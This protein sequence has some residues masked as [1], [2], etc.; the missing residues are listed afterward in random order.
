M[1][2]NLNQGQTPGSEPPPAPEVP[3]PPPAPPAPEA[4]APPPPVAPVAPAAPVAPQ[5][6][7]APP[8]QPAYPPPAQPVYAPPPPYPQTQ[9][10]GGEGQAI[11]A[12][13]IGI[14]GGLTWCLPLVGIPLA[15]IGIVL[16]VMGMKSTKRTLA[17]IGIVFCVLSL[18]AGIG[19]S[20]V[21]AVMSIQDPS[22]YNF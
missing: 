1:S 18:I 6:V 21:G 15:I 14:V 5:P 12:L 20:V 3:A 19:N 9:R 2:D 16:G 17:I 13:V 4:P 7:Y 22:F 10:T 8:P 11:A